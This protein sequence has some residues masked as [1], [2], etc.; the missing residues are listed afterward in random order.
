MKFEAHPL[1]V[2]A[3]L[4]LVGPGALMED[5]DDPDSGEWHLDPATLAGEPKAERD[6]AQ[7]AIPMP[8][9]GDQGEWTWAPGEAPD[10]EDF[11]RVEIAWLKRV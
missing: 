10:P 3:A 6:L 7:A 9:V 2:A 11:H 8:G 4:G 1:V 5:D